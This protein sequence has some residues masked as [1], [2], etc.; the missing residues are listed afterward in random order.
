MG[1]LLAIEI[2]KIYF[3]FFFGF[4]FHRPNVTKIWQFII[5]LW[6]RN[7][8]SQKYSQ[9]DIIN[10]NKNLR[11]S[12]EIRLYIFCLFL[13]NILVSLISLVVSIYTRNSLGI[14]Q[15][16]MRFCI[17]VPSILLSGWCVRMEW[18]LE[19]LLEVNVIWSHAHKSIP[20][21]LLGLYFKRSDEHTHN[22]SLGVPPPPPAT[23]PGITIRTYLIKFSLWGK[24]FQFSMTEVFLYVFLWY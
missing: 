21:T 10:S 12:F 16:L 6:L 22:F 13:L 4:L 8:Y 24:L 19:Y 18:I 9:T 5:R 15:L 23:I 20:W 7:V 14:E 1:L 17:H 3:V 11:S 2:I